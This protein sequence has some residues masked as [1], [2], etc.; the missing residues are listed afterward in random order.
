MNKYGESMTISN[1]TNFYIC[2]CKWGHMN[3]TCDGKGNKRKTKE[4]K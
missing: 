4:K 1:K 3:C 2:N